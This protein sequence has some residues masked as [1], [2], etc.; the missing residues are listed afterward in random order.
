MVGKRIS[1]VSEF[2]GCTLVNFKEQ[3]IQTQVCHIFSSVLNNFKGHLVLVKYY[4]KGEWT[5]LKSLY[6][7]LYMPFNFVY[8]Q[9]IYTLNAM[10]QTIYQNGL[11]INKDQKYTF[12]LKY[13]YQ[14]LYMP[15]N[16]YFYSL[17]WKSSHQ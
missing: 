10:Y 6:Q 16:F 17:S 11:C 5:K 7:A 15:F 2:K 4:L 13:L 12:M 9:Y 1:K 8:A 14:T 3:Y